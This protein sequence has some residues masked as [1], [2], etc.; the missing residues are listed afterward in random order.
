MAIGHA[1]GEL[2]PKIFLVS[3]TCAFRVAVRA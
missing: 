1:W 3:G 2:A